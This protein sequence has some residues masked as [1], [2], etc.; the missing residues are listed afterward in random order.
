MSVRQFVFSLATLPL[1]LALLGGWFAL[2]M[3]WERFLPAA[4]KPVDMVLT[5]SART[6]G[7]VTRGLIN[8]VVWLVV[9]MPITLVALSQAPE[10]GFGGW[11]GEWATGLTGLAVDLLILDLLAYFWHRAAHEVN[12]LW[13]FHEVHHRDEFLDVTTGMRFHFGETI[14]GSMA[15]AVFMLGI[16][17][18]IEHVIVF[19]ALV[20][21]MN[22]FS[23][24]N[25][26]LPGWLEKPLSFVIATP[27]IHWTHH[28]T[29]KPEID[30][31]YAVIL[32]W[33]DW[34]FG[35]RAAR[36][37]RLGMLLGV[38]HHSDEQLGR[39][40]ILPFVRRE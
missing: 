33:W 7:N 22:W 4:P 11:R 14:L 19:D 10:K 26:R 23:H 38:R 34:I 16:S 27:S 35:T 40:L 25:L 39:L 32:T 13:R 8:F 3:V 21:M 31:N 37:R 2:L 6:G 20:L 9:T 5:Q 17:C 29:S 18:P 36:G 1:K 12:T 30:Q 15:R 24:S 28:R